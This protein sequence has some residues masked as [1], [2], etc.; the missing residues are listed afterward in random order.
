[1]SCVTIIEKKTKFHQKS[2]IFSVNGGFAL[3][4]INKSIRRVNFQHVEI[5]CFAEKA[6]FQG[7]KQCFF[8][9]KSK[10]SL[11]SHPSFW[12]MQKLV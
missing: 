10:I 4:N 3:F 7:Q 6:P 9:P 5:I 2:R 8:H 11:F 12:Q 1:M